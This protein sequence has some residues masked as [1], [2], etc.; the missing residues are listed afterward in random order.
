[1][2][3]PNV[4]RKGNNRRIFRYI[5]YMCCGSTKILRFVRLNLK[6]VMSCS[7]KLTSN[8]KYC[9]VDQ[10]MPHKLQSLSV[11]LLQYHKVPSGRST[12][13]SEQLLFLYRVV[14][15]SIVSFHFSDFLNDNNK[16]YY[17]FPELTPAPIITATKPFRSQQA[18]FLIVVQVLDR[19][20]VERLKIPS[21]LD[22]KTE[23]SP[24]LT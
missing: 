17:L 3:R 6:N 21:I 22:R 1:M 18:I 15:K 9:C 20:Q 24:T 14:T 23:L 13:S 11:F 16:K 4:F 7:S 2:C 10:Q 8:S 19:T 12:V 5:N